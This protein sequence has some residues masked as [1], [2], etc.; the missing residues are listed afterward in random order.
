[1]DVDRVII[2]TSSYDYEMLRSDVFEIL[3]SLDRGDRGDRGL[4]RQGS[5]VLVKPNL[6]T[7]SRQEQAITTHPLIVK[8]VAEYVLS[9]GG[10]V[11]VSDS[12]PMG[13]FER[14]ITACGLKEALSGMPVEVK[15]FKDSREVQ[16]KGR[17]KTIEV[18]SDA[19][20]ADVIINLPKL[21]THSQMVLTLAVKNLFGC[22]VGM[23]KPEW[24][25]RVGENREIFAELLLTVYRALVPAINLMDGVLAMEG[26]GPGTGGTPRK[27][28]IL[29]GSD[30]AVSLDMAVCRMVGLDPF[31]LPTNNAARDMGLVNDY[32]VSGALPAIRDFA[33]P[34]ASDLLFG[35]R[36]TRKFM[37]RHLTTRPASL[38]DVC[39]LCNECVQ[40]CPAGALKRGRKGLEFDYEKC[41]RCYC[42]LEVCPHGAMKKEVPILRRAVRP[43]VKR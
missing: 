25:Y 41:I 3:S 37:R 38:N 11:Q 29:M 4:I 2:K 20:D 32:E 22:V 18:A 12:P 16:G 9:K 23:K 42:C 17:F 30:S 8:A 26:D 35:P 33:F 36:F 7:A 21:K 40:M 10:K 15:E 27:T 14:I 24:H 13:S 28:G 43:F 6:L 39:K 5:R 31:G 19:L 1:M 34:P